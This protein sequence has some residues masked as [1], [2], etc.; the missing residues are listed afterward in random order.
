MSEGIV[1]NISTFKYVHYELEFDL[2]NP[3]VLTKKEVWKL[4]VP[5]ISKDKDE[6]FVP[7]VLFSKVKRSFVTI[8]NFFEQQEGIFVISSRFS[9]LHKKKIV[10]CYWNLNHFRCLF[11][12]LLKVSH[13]CLKGPIFENNFF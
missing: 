2:N 1:C 9:S 12:S 10:C 8:Q 4:T 5:H 3:H 6:I 13:K 11:S 7:R